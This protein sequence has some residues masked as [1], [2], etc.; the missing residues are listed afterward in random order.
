MIFYPRFNYGTS[1][2]Y[3]GLYYDGEKDVDAAKGSLNMN[4]YFNNSVDGS[5]AMSS[6][7][8]VI[9][10]KMPVELYSKFMQSG[11]DSID[12]TLN[13]NASTNQSPFKCRIA[14]SDFMTPM[15][16]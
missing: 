2:L 8:S 1:P 11:K 9:S 10:M 5:Y 14:L 4:L 13:L 12:V 16:Y 6:T 15:A 3:F 7:A